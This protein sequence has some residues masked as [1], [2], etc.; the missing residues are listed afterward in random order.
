MALAVVNAR[1][2]CGRRRAPSL[3]HYCRGNATFGGAER[4]GRTI[5]GAEV[6][7]GR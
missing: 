4:W 2:F 3:L 1:R 5:R 6:M 7:D